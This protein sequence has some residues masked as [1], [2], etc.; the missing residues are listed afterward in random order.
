MSVELVRA[1][2]NLGKLAVA[3]VLAVAC[4]RY[5][6][7]VASG[8]GSFRYPGGCFRAM[9]RLAVGCE[10]DLETEFWKLRRRRLT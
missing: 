4:R 10:I 8:A 2:E 3:A 9:A 6:D 5:S 7:D 1:V